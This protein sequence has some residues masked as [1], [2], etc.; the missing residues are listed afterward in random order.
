MILMFP[1]LFLRLYN[2]IIIIT[3]QFEMKRA[4][5]DNNFLQRVAKM[6]L[7]FDGKLCYDNYYN[8][9]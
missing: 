6:C 9:C 3:L 1:P 7:L 2:I 4:I 8:F 5:Y